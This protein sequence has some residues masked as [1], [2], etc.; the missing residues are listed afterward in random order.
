MVVVVVVELIGVECDEG[1]SKGKQKQS[2]ILPFSIVQAAVTCYE[3][4]TSSLARQAPQPQRVWVR[5]GS[6]SRTVY[7][8]GPVTCSFTCTVGRVYR[9]SCQDVYQFADATARH[10]R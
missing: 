6:S 10:D 9:G 8:V 2:Y 3:T 5:E 4:R 7:S 1:S